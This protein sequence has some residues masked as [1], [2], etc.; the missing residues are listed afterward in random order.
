MALPS[1]WGGISLG[2]DVGLAALQAQLAG[3]FLGQ[4]AHLPVL[5]GPR[6]R[7]WVNAELKTAIQSLVFVAI[8]LMTHY[9]MYTFSALTL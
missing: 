6:E 3:Q 8:N 7:A 1:W 5:G 4:L 2:A 9:V